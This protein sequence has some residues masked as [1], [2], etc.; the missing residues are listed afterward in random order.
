[1]KNSSAKIWAMAV[2]G[3]AFTASATMY[4]LNKNAGPGTEFIEAAPA[5][6]KV[7]RTP[8]GTEPSR[9]V[10]E[11]STTPQTTAAVSETL[12]HHAELKNQYEN[13]EDQEIVDE[14]QKI[15][16]Q[17]EDDQ[18][19]EKANAGQLDEQKNLQLKALMRK[20]IAL[21]GIQA[22]RLLSQN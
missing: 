17:I 1:M 16:K 5:A 4:F 2:L 22:E 3:L 10:A 11:S 20:K 12:S 14:L 15:D 6:Q 13:L 7:A 9:P 8:S 21:M 19:I 18:L